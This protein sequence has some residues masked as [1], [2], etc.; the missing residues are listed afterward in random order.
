MK[1]SSD[2]RKIL[3]FANNLNLKENS[4]L[5]LNNVFIM[6]CVGAG[7]FTVEFG[8]FV[9]AGRSCSYLFS[10]RQVEVRGC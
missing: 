7:E 2:E 5:S 6:I 8:A 3:K 9:S 10:K 4:N 1:S